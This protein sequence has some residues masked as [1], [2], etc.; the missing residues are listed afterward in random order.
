MTLARAEAGELRVECEPFELADLCHA[1]VEV[2]EP[3]AECRDVSLTY[4]CRHT[5]AV[6]G[7]SGWI[8]RLL[9][10]LIDNALKFTPEGGRVMVIA[11]E[12]EGALLLETVDNGPG[13]PE[14]ERAK[15]AQAY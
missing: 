9:V 3:V 2:L 10:N 12:E 13:I 15:L 4:H 7:D 11:R 1:V 8:E 6:A 5:V 14:A